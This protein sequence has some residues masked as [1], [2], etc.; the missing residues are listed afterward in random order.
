LT[1]SFADL[2]FQVFDPGFIRTCWALRLKSDCTPGPEQESGLTAMELRQICVQCVRCERFVS[3]VSHHYHR[4]P[5]ANII[6]SEDVPKED[7]VV[8]SLE[9]RLDAMGKGYLLWGLT[10][11]EFEQ[12]FCKCMGCGRFLTTSGRLCHV[13]SFNP[14]D[15]IPDTF[16]LEADNLFV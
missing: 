1:G 7:D 9:F 2:D 13:C 14:A 16:E 6:V 8:H 5:E 12:L 4:C 15:A 10:K 11:A 3:R